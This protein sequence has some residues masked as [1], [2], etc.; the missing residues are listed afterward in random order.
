M[1][2]DEERGTRPSALGSAERDPARGSPS[3]GN[4]ERA[5]HALLLAAGSGSRFG[6]NKLLAT[7]HGRPLIAHSAAAVA[8]AIAA[9]VL[10]GGVAVAPPDA[11]ELVSHLDAAGLWVVENP[12]ARRG[13][14]TSLKRGLEALGHLSPAVGGALI[15]LGDQPGLRLDVVRRLVEAWRQTHR[16]VR[17]RYHAAPAEPGHPVLLDRSLWPLAARLSGDTGLRDLLAGQPVTLIDVPGD[18]P[19]VDTPAELRQLE[20]QR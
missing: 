15:V 7:L 6:D 16:T 20:D 17:P 11:T 19:D 9:G 10:A 12:E 3:G 1:G 5:V 8:E 14:A 18:N 2:A 13:M 4:G